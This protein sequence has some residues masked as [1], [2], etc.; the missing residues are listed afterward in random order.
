MTKASDMKYNRKLYAPNAAPEKLESNLQQTREALEEVHEKYKSM[1]A[2]NNGTIR[3]SNLDQRQRKGLMDL[4]EKIKDESV[5]MP[6]DKTMGL[7][8]ESKESYKAAAEEH[9]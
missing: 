7:N 9:I 6:T 3:E 5:I 4:K 8:I 1:R 2:D